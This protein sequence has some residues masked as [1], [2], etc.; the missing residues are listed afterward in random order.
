[1]NEAHRLCC[2]SNCPLPGTDMER[3]ESEHWTVIIHYCH[4]HARELHQGTPLGPVGVDPSRLEVE[5]KGT[6]V[7]EIG[8][9]LHA[10]GP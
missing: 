1:M 5:P 7:P 3:S 8:G 4:E 9:M 10:I 2:I 6:K